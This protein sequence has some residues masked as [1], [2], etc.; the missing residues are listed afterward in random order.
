MALTQGDGLE[1]KSEK[2]EQERGLVK[3]GFFQLIT[4]R[5]RV[6]ILAPL[7]EF[8]LKSERGDLAAGRPHDEKNIKT[9]LALLTNTM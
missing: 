4:R 6:Q 5:S 7:L 9:K 8:P 2:S 1:G 3:N